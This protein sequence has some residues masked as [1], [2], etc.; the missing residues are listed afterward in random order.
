[1]R[2]ITR[3]RIGWIVLAL[4]AAFLVIAPLTLTRIVGHEKTRHDH[5]VGAFTVLKVIDGDTVVIMMSGR[6]VKVRLIGVDT[7]ETVHPSKPVERFGIEASRSLKK[8]LTG[9]A[10][11]IEHDRVGAKLDRYGR[12]LLYL[13]L[14]DGTDINREIIAKGFGFAYTRF[15]FSR[16]DDY[17]KAETDARRKRLGLWGEDPKPEPA[18]NVIVYVTK[19]GTKYHMEGCGFLGKSSIAKP[20]NEAAGTQL[21]CERC[22]PP[23]RRL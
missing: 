23:S 15:P 20:L 9:K 5:G 6:S 17:R 16:M 10:V 11:V 3:R 4:S 2:H 12:E 7:P 1:M 19:A 8:C 14:A 21:P 13:K 18:E 22:N